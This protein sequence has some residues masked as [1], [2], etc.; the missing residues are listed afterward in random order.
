MKLVQ[1]FD[2]CPKFN[3]LPYKPPVLS[4]GRSL[5]FQSSMVGGQKTDPSPPIGFKTP[6]VVDAGTNDKTCLP[7]SSSLGACGRAERLREC[8]GAAATS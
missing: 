3:I 6:A 4:A 7:C 5:W 8:C 2:C 1:G